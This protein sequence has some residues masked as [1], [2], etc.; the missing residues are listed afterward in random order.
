M[1][2]RLLWIDYI[3]IIAI[4]CV[5]S[6]HLSA[7]ASRLLLTFTVQV[8][9]IV[10]GFLFKP[11]SFVVLIKKSCWNL[12]VPT[13]LIILATHAINYTWDFING[14]N[15][16][17]LTPPHLKGLVL[18]LLGFHSYNGIGALGGMWFVY[19]LFLCRLLLSG[20][21]QIRKP[22]PLL[23]IINLLFLFVCHQLQSFYSNNWEYPNAIADTLMGFPLYSIGYLLSAYKKQIYIT[24]L[25][26][27]VLLDIPSVILVFLCWKFNGWVLLY[28]CRYG[29]SI[30]LCILGGLA[31]TVLLYSIA[32]VLEKL[33][34]NKNLVSLLGGGTIIILGF[35]SFLIQ[36]ANHFTSV[37]H[38]YLKFGI[39]LLIL[40]AFIPINYFV[41]KYIPIMWGKYRVGFSTGS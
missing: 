16:T 40:L 37:P 23:L 1:N 29:N 34:F 7:P 19:S 9:F 15:I 20:I 13:I 10:S 18:S 5:I 25:S 2:N 33:N 24:P 11:E 3:K 36:A 22:F 38:P 39:A 27:S 8:F 17:E 6:I 30:L 26:H 12:A 35:H 21:C 28:N 31:G 41:K 4:F 14:Q 32:R